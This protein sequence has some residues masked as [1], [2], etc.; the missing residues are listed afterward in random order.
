V[1]REGLQK[2]RLN[3]EEVHMIRWGKGKIE[4][5]NAVKGAWNS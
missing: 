1:E 4:E 5:K 2:G 3:A